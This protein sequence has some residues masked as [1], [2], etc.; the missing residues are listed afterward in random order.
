[1]TVGLKKM[2]VSGGTFNANTT[3]LEPNMTCAPP[4]G[5][6]YILARQWNCTADLLDDPSSVSLLHS[7]YC[8]SAVFVIHTPLPAK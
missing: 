8:L 5:G 4:K 7:T 1:V 3:H 6:L 2:L